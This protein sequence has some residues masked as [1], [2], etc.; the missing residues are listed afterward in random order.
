MRITSIIKERRPAMTIGIEQGYFNNNLSEQTGF[1]KEDG[2]FT[3]TIS[4]SDLNLA[5]TDDSEYDFFKRE[6]LSF[7][8]KKAR[9]CLTKGFLSQVVRLEHFKSV[10]FCSSII[11]NNLKETE[12]VGF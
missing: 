11:L 12:S 1:V 8:L 7:L 6:H 5:I 10:F 4:E 2:V 9:C 3:R